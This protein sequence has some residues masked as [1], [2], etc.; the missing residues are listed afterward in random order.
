[1]SF[2]NRNVPSEVVDDLAFEP[3]RADGIVVGVHGHVLQQVRLLRRAQPLLLGR[4]LRRRLRHRGV[5]RRF[6][7]A[8]ALPPQQ[9][10]GNEDGNQGDG[11]E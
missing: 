7:A 6:V 4:L 11:N 3:Q 2:S 8:S 1:M 9:H 5:A 10:G